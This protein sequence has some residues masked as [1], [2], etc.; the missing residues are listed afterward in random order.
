MLT[1]I[2]L[3]GVV[4]IAGAAI[5]TSAQTRHTTTRS[6]TLTLRAIAQEYVRSIFVRKQITREVSTAIPHPDTVQRVEV[7]WDYL[8][9]IPIALRNC[10]GK[11]GGSGRGDQTIFG[12]PFHHD[13]NVIS[14]RRASELEISILHHVLDHC[15]RHVR[16]TSVK[17]RK[18]PDQ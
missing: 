5:A 4:L 3:V 16:E 2:P 17:V 15:D 9:Y 13:R 8:S 1:V 18:D 14:H 10:L 12:Y 11:K 6:A 7:W